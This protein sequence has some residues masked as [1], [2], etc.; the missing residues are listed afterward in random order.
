MAVASAV[1]F[2]VGTRDGAFRRP[3][4]NVAHG[5]AHDRHT[6]RRRFEH[7][8]SGSFVPGRQHE[9]VRPLIN[10][11]QR[12]GRLEAMEAHTTG[13]PQAAR[14]RRGGARKRVFAD[15]IQMGVGALEKHLKRA[16]QCVVILHRIQARDVEHTPRRTFRP[17]RRSK[18]GTIDAERNRAR[19]PAVCDGETSLILRAHSEPGREPGSRVHRQSLAH[20]QL[21]AVPDVGERDEFTAVAGDHRW[22][23]QTP[24]C[25]GCDQSRRES[26]VGVQHV[27]WAVVSQRERSAGH[28]AAGCRLAVPGREWSRRAVDRLRAADG[29]AARTRT[30][31][32][33]AQDVRRAPAASESRAA[34]RSRRIR[35]SRPARC[36][37]AIICGGQFRLGRPQ[38]RP[39]PIRPFVFGRGRP[40][41]RPN[42]AS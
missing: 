27:E 36:A 17:L 8:R 34:V 12:I 11:D 6:A 10:R 31:R 40:S 21:R 14:E 23:M 5:G 1:G 41:G 18:R 19:G 35:Q 37:C 30:H 2:W 16:E 24:A 22:D 4:G 3:V 7:N 9:E 28:I 39:L 32:A 15:D 38:G 29:T 25:S 13:N 42:C 20:S 33:D 26:P